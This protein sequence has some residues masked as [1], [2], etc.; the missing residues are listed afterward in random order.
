MP[1]TLKRNEEKNG[2]EIRFPEKPSK[3]IRETLKG[4]G[5]RWSP[6][7]ECWYIKYEKQLLTWA[8]DFVEHINAV[9]EDKSNVG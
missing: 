1:V 2:I 7:G 9:V 4:Q 5:W 6:I 8:E 3:E